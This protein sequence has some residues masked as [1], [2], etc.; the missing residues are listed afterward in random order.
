VVSEA[1]SLYQSVPCL[2]NG[3]SLE[4]LMPSSGPR[5]ISARVMSDPAIHDLEMDRVFARSWTFVAH[6]SEI[7]TPGDFV[8]RPMGSDSVIVSRSEDGEVSVLLNVCSHRGTRLCTTERGNALTFQCPYHA[9]V[10]ENTGEMLGAML[11]AQAYSVPLDKKAL[12]L[13]RARV[14]SFHG[15]IFAT[16]SPTLPDL[17]TS[18]GAMAFYL[19]VMLGGTDQGLEVAGPPQRWIINANW[20]LPAENLVG[21][22]MHILAAHRSLCE[23]GLVGTLGGRGPIAVAH[24]AAMNRLGLAGTGENRAPKGYVSL[25]D[26]EAGHGMTIIPIP[27]IGLS[28]DEQLAAYCH[29]TGVPQSSAGELKQNLGPQ[30]LGFA[31]RYFASTGTLFPNFSFIRSPFITESAGEPVPGFTIRLWH[32]TANGVTEAWSWALLEKGAPAEL[33]A[34]SRQAIMRTF[35]TSGMAEQDDVDMWARIQAGANGALGRERELVYVSHRAAE[36]DWKYP[37]EARVGMSTD[38]NQWSWYTRWHS[39]LAG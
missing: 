31:L 22:G 14:E 21:D 3:I 1:P 30:K 16:F 24:E 27:D 2:P 18:L 28:P 17:R 37:G 7:S 20:K 32:P 13:R 38:D 25:T 23:L 12:G 5:R 29:M 26:P 11:E 9:W 39:L 10:Y 35:G 34:R 6:E 36:P 33:K 19:E 4:E 15:L 8:T